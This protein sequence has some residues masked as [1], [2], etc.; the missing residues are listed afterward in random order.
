[1]RNFGFGV[2]IIIGIV[3]GYY[4]F[5][6]F[7]PSDVKDPIICPLVKQDSQTLQW[8]LLGIPIWV[9][10]PDIDCV[11]WLN[12][13]I[14]TMWPY[15]DKAILDDSAKNIAEP[16]IAGQIPKYKIQPLGFETLTLGS[17]PPSFQG[18]LS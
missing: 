14:E 13:F 11:D 8:L 3:V 7:Q 5:I 12:K 16:I 1:M 15:L 6:Y 2:G 10:H 9:K 18:S 17:L 4:L